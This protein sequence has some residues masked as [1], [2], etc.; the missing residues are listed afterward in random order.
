MARREPRRRVS[1]NLECVTEDTLI[2]SS[3]L[4]WPTARLD[5]SGR[6]RSRLLS[7]KKNQNLLNQN[8]GSVIGRAVRD[9]RA[10]T[11]EV[12]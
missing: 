2:P 5:F 12:I 1:S 8:L 3:R 9:A 4:A 7:E 11:N 10:T 6:D